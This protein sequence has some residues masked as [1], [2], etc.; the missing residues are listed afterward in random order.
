MADCSKSLQHELQRTYV[1]N[2]R[3]NKAK[4]V[5]IGVRGCYCFH[6][7]DRALTDLYPQD[8]RPVCTQM[9]NHSELFLVKNF[10]AVMQRM[11]D[12]M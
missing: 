1:L 3:C 8:E 9:S 7:A 2:W 6:I 5:Y 4:A 12:N 11:V 10:L